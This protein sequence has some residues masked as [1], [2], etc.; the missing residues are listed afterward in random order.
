MAPELPADLVVLDLKL[1]NGQLKATVEPVE[2][3]AK[4]AASGERIRVSWNADARPEG[5]FALAG[6][7]VYVRDTP[8]IIRLSPYTA[9]VD[10]VG[11]D[12]GWRYATPDP[13]MVVLM[14]P[15]GYVLGDS[16]PKPIR[17]KVMKNGRI[18]AYWIFAGASKHD[19]A[20]L[21]WKMKQSQGSAVSTVREINKSAVAKPPTTALPVSFVPEQT[22]IDS[23]ILVLAAAMIAFLMA[24]I[25]FGPSDLSPNYTP[26]IRFFA[27]LV[28]ALLSGAIV[29]R[30]RLGGK[31]PFIADDVHVAAVGGF[32]VFIFVMIFWLH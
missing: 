6:G 14:F 16:R 27:A 31:I 9:D 1:D 10:L 8:E 30:L 13:I 22:R 15:E 11:S 21:S 20:D 18:A 25:F 26:I 7:A 32:A 3:T 23:P 29:G 4:A 24:L 17:A 5:F 28:G 2:R 19:E 12:Y